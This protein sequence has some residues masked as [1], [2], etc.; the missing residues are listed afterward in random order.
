M[1]EQW[2]HSGS[3]KGAEFIERLPLMMPYTDDR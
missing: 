2:K 1:M 3:N